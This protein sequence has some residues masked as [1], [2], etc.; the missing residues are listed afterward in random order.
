MRYVDLALEPASAAAA[1]A[2][3]DQ[4]QEPG[5]ATCELALLGK[6]GIWLMQVC[7]GEAVMRHAVRCAVRCDCAALLLCHHLYCCY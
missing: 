2:D 7:K 5:T 1:A 4:Q 6:D 3:S